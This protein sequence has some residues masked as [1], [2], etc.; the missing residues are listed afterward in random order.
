MLEL[1]GLLLIRSS[2]HVLPLSQ[3]S[4]YLKEILLR[5]AHSHPSAE[6]F[7]PGFRRAVEK[8]AA[9]HAAVESQDRVCILH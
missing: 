1:P 9:N 3:A 8:D 7:G 6:S 5:F 4:S 2:T